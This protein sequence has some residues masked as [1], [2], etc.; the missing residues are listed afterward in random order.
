MY[1]YIPNTARQKKKKK[2]K[3]SKRKAKIFGDF[4]RFCQSFLQSVKIKE[5]LSY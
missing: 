5:R 3:M 1:I 2:D 4:A